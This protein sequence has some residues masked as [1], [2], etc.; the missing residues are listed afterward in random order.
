MTAFDLFE[1]KQSGLF[2]DEAR[3]GRRVDERV[4]AQAT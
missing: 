1:R 4:F 2:A 3:R